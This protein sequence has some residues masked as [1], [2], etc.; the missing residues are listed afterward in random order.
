MNDHVAEHPSIQDTTSPVRDLARREEPDRY[1]AALLAPAEAS[2]ALLTLAAFAGELARI[3]AAVSDPMIGEIRLQWWRD[4]VDAAGRGE[5]SGHPVGDALA[6]LMPS[7]RIDGARLQRMIDARAFYLSGELHA[8][9]AALAWHLTETEGLAFDI[10]HEILT[11]RPLPGSIA[12]DAGLAY[13][14][15][16]ALGRLPASLHNGGF[17]IP[18]TLLAENGVTPGL[19]AERPFAAATLAGTGNAVRAL[20]AKAR[21]AHAEVRLAIADLGWPG[22]IAVLPLATVEPY[23]RAVARAGNRAGFHPLEHIAELMPLSRIWALAR[24]RLQ[25][26]V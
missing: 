24:A 10:A 5:T 25:K 2:S 3:P 6:S 19:L 13:G 8:D 12:A 14:L 18:A 15:A 26:R 21:K 4:A 11:G 1:L 16:R 7:H 9:D 17:P 20:T 23:L 22:S